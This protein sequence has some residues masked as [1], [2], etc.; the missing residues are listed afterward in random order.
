MVFFTDVAMRA[1]L[2]YD[3]FIL[4]SISVINAPSRARFTSPPV[5][6]RLVDPLAA[7]NA[8]PQV[9]VVEKSDFDMDKLILGLAWMLAGKAI[10]KAKGL[11]VKR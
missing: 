4:K 7:Y 8:S 11:P 3:L 2:R 6:P 9:P 5:P 10:G 1:A